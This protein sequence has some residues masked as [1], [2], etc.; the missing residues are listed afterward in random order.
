M[1]ILKKTKNQI[2]QMVERQLKLDLRFID[3][4]KTMWQ[5]KSCI[6]GWSYRKKMT[7][8]IIDKIENDKVMIKKAKELVKN[9]LCKVYNKRLAELLAALNKYEIIDVDSCKWGEC[10]IDWNKNR[11]WG[12]CPAGSYKNGHDYNEFRAVTGCGFDKLSSLTANMFNQDDYLIAFIID[13]IEKNDITSDNIS[14]KL[15]YGIRISSAT[16]LP[17][18]EGGVGVEC[19]K[20]ILEKLGFN[21]VHYETKKADIISFK[22]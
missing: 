11:T 4:I 7:N 13:Y 14:N 16:C 20:R 6:S 19:H 1:T 12:N 2:K 22:R 10:A 21:V 18:F 15:G 5:M 3:E 9:R 17:Y 8:S